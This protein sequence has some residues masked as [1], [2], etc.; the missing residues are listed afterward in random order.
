MQLKYLLPILITVVVTSVL[1][2]HFS[3]K[4]PDY[5]KVRASIASILARPSYDFGS[6]APILL[7]L[8]W[9]SSGTYNKTDRTGGSNG[10]TMR[11]KPEGSDPA[12]SGLELARGFLEDIKKLYPDISYSDLWVLASYVAIEQMGGPVIEFIPG[13]TDAKS[14]SACPANGRLPEG[15]KNRTHIREVFNRMGFE[16][17]EIVALIGGGHSVGKCHYNFTRYEGPWTPTPINFTND[18]FN[19]LLYEN[20]TVKAWSGEKQFEDGSKT[21][22]MMPTDLELRDDP[23]FRKWSEIYVNDQKLFFEDFGKAFKKLTELGFK[24]F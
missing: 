17:R 10:A 14:P 7:R 20:W 2:V 13:R 19:E 24:Q 9:H 1:Y 11:F 3:H 22:M 23:E 8:G 21:L 16:D 15:S 4:T 18:F 12:N 6:I 5:S